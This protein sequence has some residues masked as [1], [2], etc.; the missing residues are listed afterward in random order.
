MDLNYKEDSSAATDANFVMGE[1]DELIEIQCSAE[2]TDAEYKEFELMYDA[3]LSVLDDTKIIQGT[4]V[5]KTNR[6]FIIDIGAKSEGVI[7]INEF[8]YNPDFKVGESNTKSCII[9]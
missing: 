8:R 4:I 2:K 9:H 5:A 6:D 3:T 7:S 1:K